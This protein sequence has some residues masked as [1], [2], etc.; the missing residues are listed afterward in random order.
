MKWEFSRKGTAKEPG[1]NLMRAIV[2]ALGLLAAQLLLQSLG[3]T[4]SDL[5]TLALMMVLLMFASSRW[6]FW[7]LV[8][9]FTAVATLYCVVGREYGLPSYQYLVS[10]LATDADEAAEFL[11]LVPWTTWGLTALLPVTVAAFYW[12][13]LKSGMQPCRSKALVLATVLLLIVAEKPTAFV[14]HLQEAIRDTRQDQAFLSVMAQRNDWLTDGIVRTEP[15]YRNYV[16]VLGESARR[17]YLHAYGYPVSNTPFLDAVNG[18]VVEGMTSAGTNTVASLRFMLTHDRLDKRPDYSRTIVGLA[19]AGG[20]AT[21][22]F[23]NQGFSSE[24]DTPITAVATPADKKIFVRTGSYKQG[25]FTDE[26]LL[27]PLRQ[28]LQDDETRPRFIVLHIMGSHTDACKRIAHWPEKTQTDERHQQVA[29]YSD[30]MAQTDRFLE[31]VY[32]RL[33]ATGESFSM[34]YTSDHGLVLSESNG[35][36]RL[37]NT[38]VSRHHCDIPLVKISSD[39]TTHQRV[40]SVKSGFRFTDGL[41]RWLGLS[42]GVLTGYDL[43]DGVDDLETENPAAE[44]KEDSA[45]D[46]GPFVRSAASSAGGGR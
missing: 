11:S 8:A 22:W 44:G 23:S 36:L 9:P 41:G 27:A 25:D 7:G 19:K 14:S 6:T 40:K 30:S 43:F 37:D 10:L 5:T 45:V 20:Y 26:L 12:L 17:D 1:K 31:N 2:A 13:F 3:E 32:R 46:I 16:L 38:T 33:Q 18:T 4:P 21:Y 42:G 28:A 15:R 29:C 34:I 35:R 24:F 39:D